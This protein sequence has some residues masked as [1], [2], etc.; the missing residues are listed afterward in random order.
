MNIVL[1]KIVFSMAMI[2]NQQGCEVKIT[3]ETGPAPL[4]ATVEVL[5]VP[6]EVTVYFGD[7]TPSSNLR[8]NEH[9]YHYVGNPR[10][11]A[12]VAGTD[13]LLYRCFG[14]VTVLPGKPVS[15]PDD[16]SGDVDDSSDK[17]DDLDSTNKTEFSE[18]ISSNVEVTESTNVQPDISGSM[19][20]DN[21]TIQVIGDNNSIHIDA[22]ETNLSVTTL[23]VANAKAKPVHVQGFLPKFVHTA[24]KVFEAMFHAADQAF[25]E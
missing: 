10:V 4:M 2:V 16:D 3:N 15:Y 9:L 19:G 12:I 6:G 23:K 5:A 1:A 22:A 14:N 24:L 7:T 8:L 11:M 25:F 21:Q 20:D 17:D 13:G 18:S